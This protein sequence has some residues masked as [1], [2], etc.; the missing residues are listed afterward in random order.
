MRNAIIPLVFLLA[1]SCAT[2]TGSVYQ[3]DSDDIERTIRK[4][5]IKKRKVKQ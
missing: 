1:I 5:L 3:Y 4:K 2:N